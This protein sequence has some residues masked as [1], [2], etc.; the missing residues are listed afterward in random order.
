MN[1]ESYY[2]EFLTRW[3]L[4]LEMGGKISDWIN[5]HG[6]KKICIWGVRGRIAN[7]VI[8]SLVKNENKYIVL[9]FIDGS[10]MAINGLRHV[11]RPSEIPDETDLI[12]VVPG[13]DIEQIKKSVDNTFVDKLVG[14]DKLLDLPIIASNVKEKTEFIG[15]AY[16]GHNVVLTGL[17][18]D[19]I[20]YSAG[21][22]ED[23]SFDEE[24][25]NR[26]QCKIFCF[27]PTPRAYDHFV[28]KHLIDK[29]SFYRYGLSGKNKMERFYLPSNDDYVSGSEFKRGGE[30]KKDFHNVLMH[31][32]SFIMHEL[33]H[34]HID[35][36]KMDIEGSEFD[37]IAS[38][39][40]KT[41]VKQICMEI[42]QRF[43]DNGIPKLLRMNKKLRKLGYELIFLSEE[44][45][46]YI[47]K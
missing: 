15:S 31:D 47:K 18:R 8:D 12:V 23:T 25:F 26:C 16:G 22:G 41:I 40:E 35:L 13:Y 1:K 20:V 34:N 21:I 42:H 7:L 10:E 44:N 29:M 37:V 46:T 19:S 39:N 33:G 4:R 11:I 45:L 27:D 24:L 3:I 43:F 17:N 30:L 9:A 36:L 38:L 32:L 2:K 14:I 6:Y 5:A 28:N